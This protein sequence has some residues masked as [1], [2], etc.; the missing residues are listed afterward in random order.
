MGIVCI[1]DKIC[2]HTKCRIV[3]SRN[4]IKVNKCRHN[5]LKNKS[6]MVHGKILLGLS[7]KLF[8]STRTFLKNNAS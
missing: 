5:V 8:I 7:L 6:I 3:L 2:F 4:V 1:K